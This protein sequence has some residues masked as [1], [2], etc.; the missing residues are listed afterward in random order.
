MGP[1]LAMGYG[2][3]N[4]VLGCSVYAV[5]IF[6]FLLFFSNF[7]SASTDLC[8]HVQICVELTPFVLF[9][10]VC[11][12]PSISSSRFNNDMLELR[13]VVVDKKRVGGVRRNCGYY[14]FVTCYKM[15]V[16]SLPCCLLFV[17]VAA[18][19]KRL[20]SLLLLLFLL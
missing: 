11:V 13:T 17:A 8:K 15:C 19:T 14:V 6:T 9:A 3:S 1:L 12:F 2:L 4:A 16:L 20:L 7:T 10:C 18:A 5:Q